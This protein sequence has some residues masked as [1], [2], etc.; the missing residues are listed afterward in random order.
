MDNPPGKHLWNE[1]LN[2]MVWSESTG[3]CC[4]RW[5]NREISLE[6]ANVD[7]W[8]GSMASGLLKRSDS[9]EVISALG[10]QIMIKE[11]EE[12]EKRSN[13]RVRC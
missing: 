3:C 10:E 6:V 5:S 13:C 12:K 4:C 8:T 9:F 11:T 2:M 1:S 7:R